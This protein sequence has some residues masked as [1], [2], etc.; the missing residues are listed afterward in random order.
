MRKIKIPIGAQVELRVHVTDQ[1]EADYRECA[2]KASVIGGDVKD[3]ETC[4]WWN[5]DIGREG[6]CQLLEMEEL[7]EDQDEQIN[8]EK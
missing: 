2:A 4:S 5:L 7:L 3:C 1:M 6:I 8:T